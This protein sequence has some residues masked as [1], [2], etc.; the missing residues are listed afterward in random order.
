MDTPESVK[1]RKP[2]VFVTAADCPQAGRE[3][4]IMPQPIELVGP[5]VHNP[6]RELLKRMNEKGADCAS[7]AV[8]MANLLRQLGCK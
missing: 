8:E 5:K 1:S 7:A 3:R 6:E 4:M 2:G